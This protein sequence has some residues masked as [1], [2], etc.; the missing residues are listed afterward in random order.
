MSNP[1]KVKKMTSQVE[2]IEAKEVTTPTTK[3][4]KI[5]HK[6]EK[7]SKKATA[8]ELSDEDMAMV[9]TIISRVQANQRQETDRIRSMV[10][11]NEDSVYD[12]AMTSII[13]GIG[14]YAGFK[15][16]EYVG[17]KISGYL[18]EKAVDAAIG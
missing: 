3:E 18:A 6:K 4:S 13:A 2:T 16:G 5:Q 14:I 11:S 1:K 7:M 15:V 8:V 17:K 12:V 9:N 10:S